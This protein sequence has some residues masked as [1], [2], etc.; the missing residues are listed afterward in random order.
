MR[1][2]K[3]EKSPFYYYEFQF[4]G[5]QS[6]GSTGETS[7]RAAT[8]VA[9]QTYDKAVLDFEERKK[10]GSVKTTLSIKDAF[11]RFWTEKGSKRSDSGAILSIL[12]RTEPFLVKLL[13]DAGKEPTLANVTDAEVEKLVEWRKTH[14]VPRTVKGK[15]TEDGPII[16]P[17]T[18][19][20]T[21]KILSEVMSRA[22]KRWKEDLPSMPIWSDRL[23]REPKERVRSLSAEEYAALVSV[24]DPNYETVMRFSL[25]S[26]FRQSEALLPKSA[27]KFTAGIIETIG[28]G[29]KEIERPITPAME[30]ILRECW[31][32][33][34]EMV[35][36]YTV[37]RT[38]LRCKAGEETK[39]IRGQREPITVS[40]LKIAWR[41][42]RAKGIKKVPSLA[43]FRWHDLRH[44]F[45]THMQDTTLDLRATQNALNHSSSKTTERY[46]HVMHKRVSSA[47]MAAE[48]SHYLPGLTG[49]VYKRAWTGILQS[50]YGY[51][52]AG[53][54]DKI[55]N[56]ATCTV[57]PDGKGGALAAFAGRQDR[58]SVDMTWLIKQNQAE[59]G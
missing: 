30:S 39:I 5:K 41:R 53:A 20:Y 26:G 14:R 7:K 52:I 22:Q 43:D 47:M 59:V 9:Q 50:P 42:F 57:E 56:G 34:P 12:D 44:T 18:V 11:Q 33:H 55:M 17:R 54:D 58:L 25:L 3:R 28:K 35:F 6:R 10:L 24:M 49:D 36:T 13:T 48:Q 2:Y 1:V 38:K 23:L 40:G 21:T 4:D 45:A 16:Q 15:R 29:S 32:H 8:V 27:V 31:D 46:A 19:N 51:L 37:K